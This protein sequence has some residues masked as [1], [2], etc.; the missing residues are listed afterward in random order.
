MGVKCLRA[1][2]LAIAAML[3]A[4]PAAAQVA[5]TT[6]SLEGKITDVVVSPDGASAALTVMGMPV[7][8]PATIPIDTPTTTY[9]ALAARGMTF[10]QFLLGPTMPA[11][12]QAGF[13]GGTLKASG[14]YNR[15]RGVVEIRSAILEPSENIIIGEITGATCTNANCTAPG[16][17]IVMNNGGLARTST[18][19]RIAFARPRSALGFLVNLNQ[20]PLTGLGVVMEGYYGDLDPEFR[21]F[22]F[23]MLTDDAVLLATRTPEVSIARATCT[24]DGRLDIRGGT[25]VAVNAAG[26]GTNNPAGRVDLFDVSSGT[27]RSLG[28]ANALRVLA[29]PFGEYRLRA[30][31]RTCPTR[32]QARWPGGGVNIV[33]PVTQVSLR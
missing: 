8:L 9:E 17:G 20:G 28:A 7:E 33:S 13:L 22:D 5:P 1:S 30:T 12:A 4:G 11:R 26:V 14:I 2:L 24:A 23:E 19:A 10:E 16:D 21:W 31:V 29:T 32:L 15:A 18:D 27:A 25:H 3:A 6:V